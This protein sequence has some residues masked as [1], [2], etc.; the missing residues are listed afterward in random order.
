[1][2][3]GFFADADFD[4]EAR[5]ALGRVANG[6]GDV[7]LILAVLDQI[8]D[9]DRQSWFDSWTGMASTLAG[10]GEEAV[11]RGHLQ[12]ASW[13]LLTAAAYYAKAL[14]AVYGLADQ[15]VLMPTFR[16]QQR[17][18][19]GVIDASAGRFVRVQVLYE[20]TTLPGYLLRPAVP[21]RPGRRSS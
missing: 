3:G 13:A 9:S 18:W 1:M 12:T 2:P 10:Q 19:E 6:T 20:G 21:G 4:F 16:E 15:S 11:R 17:C 5:E 14:T 8:V 7:G